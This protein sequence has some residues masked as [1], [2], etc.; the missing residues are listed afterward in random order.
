MSA[1]PSPAPLSPATIQALRAQTP[2]TQTSV[3]FNHAGSSL[4]SSGTVQ[5]IQAHLHR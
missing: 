4:P 5:A 3:H 2:G 1:A